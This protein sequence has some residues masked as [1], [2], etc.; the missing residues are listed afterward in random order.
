MEI[1]F[2][3][4]LLFRFCFD[5]LGE[6][7]FSAYFVPWS[8]QADATKVSRIHFYSPNFACEWGSYLSSIELPLSVRISRRRPRRPLA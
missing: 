3:V 1:V 8:R 7:V 4:F 2:D 5:L 6:H